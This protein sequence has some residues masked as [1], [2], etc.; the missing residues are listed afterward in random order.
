[1]KTG[2]QEAQQPYCRC[3][4]LIHTDLSRRHFKMEGATHQRHP[5]PAWLCCR[6]CAVSWRAVTGNEMWWL[7]AGHKGGRK[8]KTEKHPSCG[9]LC[10]ASAKER[11][12]SNSWGFFAKGSYWKQRINFILKKLSFNEA[13]VVVQQT[14]SGRE[15]MYFIVSV[16]LPWWL[17]L[18]QRPGGESPSYAWQQE[19]WAFWETQSLLFSPARG[20]YP[21][22]SVQSVAIYPGWTATVW[23]SWVLKRWLTLLF[24]F[25]CLLTSM[26]EGG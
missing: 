22:I 3:Q 23:N 12:F 14:T 2:Y 20:L 19:R 26:L 11:C 7:G 6:P 25:L 8:G 10:L 4:Q 17:T 5:S 16:P 15:N 21:L 24:V 9:L 1:M 18:Y 13:V